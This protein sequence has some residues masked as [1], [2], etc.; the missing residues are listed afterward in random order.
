MKCLKQTGLGSQAK[1]AEPLTE[2]EEEILWEKGIIG[3]HL[4]QALLNTVFFLNSICFA[5]RSVRSTPQLRLKDCQ[6]CVV[7]KYGE[8]AYLHYKEDCSKNN[9]G[10]LK[11]RKLKLKEVLQYKNT[12]N[13]ARCPV[14]LY[15]LYQSKCPQQSNGNEFYHKPL[16]NPHGNIWRWRV[17]LGHNTLDVQVC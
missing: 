2:A 13:R 7:Q 5:L 12:D 14:R 17:L 3:D 6:I 8:K 1:Q 10:R 15:K 9:S 16:Q 4:P 11:S